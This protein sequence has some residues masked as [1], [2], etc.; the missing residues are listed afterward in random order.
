MLAEKKR[1]DTDGRYKKIAHTLVGQCADE[2]LTV[3]EAAWVL[4]LAQGEVRRQGNRALV[5]LE[6]S[7]PSY[8]TDDHMPQSTHRA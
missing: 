1:W 7:F 6:D 2:N 8:C 5:T 4:G 3:D